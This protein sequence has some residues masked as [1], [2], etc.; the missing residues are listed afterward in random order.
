MD[1]LCISLVH[2]YL[3]STNSSL[4]DQFKEKYRPQK[5]NVE[6][7]EVLSKWKEE[8]LVKGLVYQH[9]KIVAPSLAIEFRERHWSSLE[10][11]P[12]HLVGD[13]EK[14]W[15]ITNTRGTGKVESGGKWEQKKNILTTEEKLV[16]ELIHQHLKTV[17]PSLAVEF[18]N[19]HLYDS[20]PYPE[21]LIGE[22]QKKVWTVANTTTTTGI[23]RV[24]AES[25]GKR[26]QSNNGKRLGMKLNTFTSV[27]LVRI[28]EA[29][30]NCED[31]GTVAKEMGRS[32][33]SVSRKMTN[34]RQSTGMKKG[35]FSPEEIERMNQAVANNEDYKS[36]SEELCRIP[37]SVYT[38]MFNKKGVTSN[39]QRKFRSYTFEEDLSVLDKIIPQLKSKMLSSGGFLSQSVLLEL[40]KE[41]QRKVDSLSTRWERVLQPWL[42]QYYT[43]TTG[44]RI[45]RMLTSLVAERFSDTRGIDW[46]EI[47]KQHQEFVGHTSASISQ[48]YH[49]IHSNYAKTKKVD[50]NLQE[51]ADYAAEVYQPGKEKKESTAK[52][53]RRE[54][55]I[56]YFKKRVTELGIEVVV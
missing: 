38:W 13:I 8:Q 15:A 20:E 25:G 12:K 52:A 24:E 16:R 7:K 37:K 34:L 5:T 42:L 33:N 2:Q 27:E 22:L 32:Y 40:S 4:A 18:Q 43:G 10:T 44:F 26:N 46:S 6:L 54:K 28:K 21:Y 35:K 55:I 1:P 56:F 9:L 45:E 19:R 39:S 53:L 3:K 48:I 29:M 41:H 36:V 14:V 51:V 50:V 23:N 11:V 49:R 30:A 17:A 47:L 31:I